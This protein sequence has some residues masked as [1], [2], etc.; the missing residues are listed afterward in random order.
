L[1]V[2]PG[3]V[4]CYFFD[5]VIELWRAGELLEA[6]NAGRACHLPTDGFIVLSVLAFVVIVIRAIFGFGHFDCR[7]SFVWG[8]LSRRLCFLE[9]SSSPI[10]A[11]G[12]VRG[13]RGVVGIRL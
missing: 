6:A 10:G 5:S 13:S 7:D 8:D 2:E 11:T 12:G 9:L 1:E 4:F 3:S